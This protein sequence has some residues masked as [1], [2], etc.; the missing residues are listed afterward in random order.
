[1]L[2][3]LFTF[4]EWMQNLF[5]GEYLW[6]TIGTIVVLAILLIVLVCLL[7]PKPKYVGVY[8]NEEEGSVIVDKNHRLWFVDLYG[9]AE[10]YTL[11][12]QKKIV[13]GPNIFVGKDVKVVE[14]TAEDN[15]FFQ[16]RQAIEKEYLVVDFNKKKTLTV[17][18]LEYKK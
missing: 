16:K 13:K 9:E 15:E 10:K 1:M 12:E 6:L 8:H 14:V 5:T 18:N 11:N 4:N 7:W 17:N 3:T 2:R